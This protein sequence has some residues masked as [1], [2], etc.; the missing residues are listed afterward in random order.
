MSLWG[1]LLNIGTGG[2][3]GSLG[4]GMNNK[5]KGP[6]GDVNQDLINY[7]AP[8]F[9]NQANTQTQAANTGFADLTQSKGDLGYVTN[10]L[11]T[12]MN[13]SDD[14]ILK[15]INASDLTKEYDN[16]TEMQTTDA[17]RGGSRSAILSQLPFNKQAN[18][19][20][21]IKSLRFAAPGQIANIAQ[22][23]AGIG[24]GELNTSVGAGNQASNILFGVEG[25]NQQAKDRKSALI[26]NILGV[27]G[28]ALGA[29][30]GGK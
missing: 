1:K 3:T 24:Q 9:K 29:W 28:T 26:G 2:I 16:Q 22:I 17:V 19:L 4:I 18:I 21:T 23:L 8:I 12:I 27:G 11:K 20:N 14:E 13:G 15:L 25:I 5:P 30:L 7:L 6:F 10:W